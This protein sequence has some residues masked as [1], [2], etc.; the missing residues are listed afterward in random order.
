MGKL[1][2]EWEVYFEGLS[3]TSLGEFISAM[4]TLRTLEMF[5]DE[6]AW[7]HMFMLLQIARSVRARRLG[8]SNAQ[9]R[10]I[11]GLKAL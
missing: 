5:Y 9:Y 10:E 7:T 8:C 6:F 1:I 11:V 4:E 2:G 3:D